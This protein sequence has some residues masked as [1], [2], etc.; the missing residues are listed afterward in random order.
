MNLVIG[1]LINLIGY[2]NGTVTK[3]VIDQGIVLARQEHDNYT[4][5][6]AL[7]LGLTPVVPT[8]IETPTQT[9]TP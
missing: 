2:A 3:D 7:V 1:T 9:P 8:A 6:L 4:I 5:E